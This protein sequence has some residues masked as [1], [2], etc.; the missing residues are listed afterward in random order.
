M[1]IHFVRSIRNTADCLTKFLPHAQHDTCCNATV[2][3]QRPNMTHIRPLRGLFKIGHATEDTNTRLT[4][5]MV[6]ST[7]HKWSNHMTRT[8]NPYMEDRFWRILIRAIIGLN[9][10][11]LPKT[12]D[13]NLVAYFYHDG[14]KKPG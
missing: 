9:T 13:L 7:D 5:I 6:S 3:C 14:K 4:H 12:L 1:E 11:L 2:W 8:Y 10:F